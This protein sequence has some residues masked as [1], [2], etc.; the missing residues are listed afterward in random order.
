MEIIIQTT[1]VD[2]IPRGA[3]ERERETVSRIDNQISREERVL[4]LIMISGWGR[5]RGPADNRGGQY[6]SA[7]DD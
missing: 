2:I 6:V 4:K 3:K 7:F 5:G 1:L